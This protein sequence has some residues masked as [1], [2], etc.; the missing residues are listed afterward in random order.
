MFYG[1]WIVAAAFIVQFF[2]VGFFTYG[3]PLLV[4]PVQKEFDAS[5]TQILLGVSLGAPIGAFASPFVGPL[6]DKWSA[7]GLVIIGA[8]SLTLGLGCMS[9]A[10]SATQ[11]VVAM[12]LLLGIANLMLGPMTATTLVARWFHTSRGFALGISATGTSVGGIFVPMLVTGLVD[13][14][15]WR[16]ALQALSLMCALIVVPMAAFVLRN[17]PSDLGLYP[18]G[19]DAPIVVP[20]APAIPSDARTTG[21]ILRT[22]AFWLIGCSLGFLFMAYVGVLTNLGK[23]AAALDVAPQQATALLS[24]IAGAGF[25]GKILF[26]WVAD[27]VSLRLELWAAQALAIVGIT[28]LSLEPPYLVMVL[29]AALMGLAA[30][31]ML[32]VWGAMIGAAFGLESFGRVMGLMMPVITVFNVP[33][34]LV[35]AASMDVTG[36]YGLALQGFVVALVIAAALLI[37][38]SLPDHRSAKPA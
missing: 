12:G 38:L 20:G 7:R 37:P 22:P 6:V 18:D 35:A 11:F 32:P 2:M 34:P 5:V 13:S 23:Y 9:L 27:R 1:W 21:E 4:E 17:H 29:A 25:V 16:E 24:T 8:L 14:M 26:G 15:S 28:L 36:S 30:G 19:A 33:G 3:F 10:Q 31:G